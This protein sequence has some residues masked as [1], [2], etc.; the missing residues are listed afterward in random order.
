MRIFTLTGQLVETV[1]RGR[2]DPGHQE[3]IIDT[4]KLTDGAYMLHLS[5]GSFSTSRV[6]LIQH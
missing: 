3:I 1:Y 6:V 4:E 2:Q 5:N